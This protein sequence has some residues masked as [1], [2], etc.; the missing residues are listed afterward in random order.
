MNVIQSVVDALVSRITQ[1]R[2]RPVFLTNGGDYRSR[3][4]AKQMNEFLQGEFHALRAYEIGSRILRDA[5]VMDSGCLKVMEKDGRVAIE[6]TLNTEI[7]VDPNDGLYGHPQN[8][9]QMY[10]INRDILLEIFPDC[11]HLILEAAQA[12]PTQTNR[13][14]E[15]VVDQVMVV[16]G[17][18]LPSSAKSKDGSHMLAISSGPLHEESWSKSTFP[19][20]FQNFSERVLG[21]WGQGLAEQLMGTQIEINKLLITSSRAINLVG[22]PRVFVEDGSKIVKQHLNNEVGSIITYRG[23]PPQYTVAPSNHPEVYQRLNDLVNYAYQQSGMSMLAAAGK[24]PSGLDAGVALREYDDIQSERFNTLVQRYQQFYIDL[25]YQ[26]LW[27]AKEIADRDGK[28]ST[29]YPSKDG[30]KE[31]DLP[32]FDIANDHFVVQCYSASALPKDPAGRMQK[33]SE[34]I[35]AGMIDIKEGRRLLDFPDLDQ[36]ERLANAP[37]ERIYQVLDK[38]IEEGEYIPPDPFMDLQEADKISIF[39]Y[40]LYATTNLEEEKLE[41]LRTF[42][43][44]VKDLKGAAMAAQPTQPEQLLATPE[45][46]PQS[47]LIPQV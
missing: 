27:K 1:D 26:V 29:V 8:M 17:W 31:I 14:S 12:Y 22:V 7:L 15:S 35:Q 46:L 28:Y 36:T 39:Y 4:L 11:H 45:P 6:R 19:Y 47:P 23:T 40:N 38:V 16:E 18:H 10:L 37:L 5:C 30:T 42:N 21:F 34:M 41:M 24:K 33:V 44:Q 3:S 13:Q 32:K 9:Y 20:I 25:A 43:A 2:P